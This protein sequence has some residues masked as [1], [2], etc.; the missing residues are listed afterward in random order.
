M[1]MRA[2]RFRCL[3]TFVD[4]VLEHGHDLL[5][6]QL[7]RLREGLGELTQGDGLD[8]GSRR[9]VGHER[10]PLLNRE[11]SGVTYIKAQEHKPFCTICTT[12]RSEL[13][14]GST[15]RRIAGRRPSLQGAPWTVGAVS[16]ARVKH[17]RAD[18]RRLPSMAGAERAR[19]V[20]LPAIPV[21]APRDAHGHHQR[22]LPVPRHRVRVRR[23]AEVGDA[24]PLR[25]LPA[26]SVLAG[27]HLCRRALEQ[28]RY[29]KGEP[30]FYESSPGVKRYFC[31]ACGSPMAYHRREW[32][33]EVHLF[34]GT[35]ADPAQW[36]P[37]GHA[38]RPSRCVV[39][40]SRSSAALREN[41]ARLQ[42]GAQRSAHVTLPGGLSV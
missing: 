21:F 31:T 11:A 19:A 22:P 26:R 39:R 36:P 30:T 28:F 3:V 17:S 7:V 9:G 41:G 14:T 24:L 23:R 32:P 18:L 42:G 6:G 27:R 8:F 1:R 16:K 38:T 20:R 13:P 35:L 40:G 25:E 4:H 34:H 37:T 33:G 5:L 12:L 29:L 2:P 10:V 15:V